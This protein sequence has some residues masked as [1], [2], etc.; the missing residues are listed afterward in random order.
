MSP[1]RWT[2][3]VICLL[4]LGAC[5][6]AP[7]PT[8]IALLP[9]ASPSP[10]T[11]TAG[12]MATSSP[13]P[14]PS[15]P[16][17]LP[18]TS[19]PSPLPATS[20]PVSIPPS[21]A[22]LSPTATQT[23]PPLPSPVTVAPP[24]G[25]GLLAW[26]VAEDGA[27]F[28]L[29]SDHKV[30][31]LEPHDLFPL[32]FS[33]ALFGAGAEAP[34][35]VAASD[36]QVFVSSDA[37]SRTLVLERE[38]L[39]LVGELEGFGPL[40]VG[41][42]GRLFMIPQYLE[43]LWPYG[44]FEIWVYD[45]TDL[46]AAPVKVRRTGMTFE[47]LVIDADSRRLYLL[48]SSVAASPP[49][50]GQ[51][52]A[53][54]DLDTLDEIAQFPWERGIL[55][56]PAI[57]PHTAEVLA[58][59]IG[60]NWSRRLLAF[61]QSGEEVRSLRSVDGQPAIDPAGRW[62]YLL[63][64]QGLWLL[65][66]KDLAVQG[67][68]P[69]SGPPPEDLALSPDGQILYL[70][71]NGWLEALPTAELQS[72]GLAPFGPLPAAWFSAGETLDQM[73][74]RVYRSP[75]MDSDGV[76]FVQMVSGAI[77]VLETYRTT[78]GGETWALLP[79][80]L[81]PDLVGVPYLSLSPN[82][83]QDRTL[84]V[85]R[86]KHVMRSTDG[87]LSWA[88]WQPRIAFSSDRDGNREIYTADLEGQDVRRV[89]KSPASEE[90]PAW[91]PAWTTLAFQSDRSGNWDIYTVQADCGGDRD[92]A[93]ALKQLTDS[94]GHD[95][96]PAW[97]PDGRSIAFVST[98]DGNP[99]IYVMDTDGGNQRRLTF[100]GGGDWRPAWR[101]NSR[102]LLFVSDRGGNNDI[103]QLEVPGP[104][105]G[106]TDAEPAVTPVVVGPAD[107]RDPAVRTEYVPRLVYLSDRDGIMRTYGYDYVSS[108]RPATDTDQ[109]EA[110]PATLTGEPYLILVT[111]EREGSTDIFRTSFY[112]DYEPLIASAGFDGQPA[113]EAVGWRPEFEPSLAWLE[114]W[115]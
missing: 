13:V 112:S 38:G 57:H 103:Y 3:L 109:P 105:D 60:L 63:R 61:D 100:D 54:W 5:G 77:N 74:A 107:D 21:P 1:K 19:H 36:S 18:P 17:A 28:V 108:P 70:L 95:M 49:H 85:V 58:S 9:S 86:D 52:Y 115:E 62:I 87:G 15:T 111:L 22:T 73:Q 25:E 101:T 46:D 80:L 89:T 71:G 69:F 114:A 42:D 44:N 67:L 47:D 27:V 78:D 93:C 23:P 68:L 50:E 10:A 65:R 32:A 55:S 31:E 82:F 45:L 8:P 88:P 99:E 30:F 24:S 110:H 94:P 11:S 16:S 59:R 102:Q 14:A 84:A 75:Q 33:A 66:N 51:S 41:P 40:S 104:G 43:K 81:R 106:S 12:V 56:R 2:A 90:N 7:A 53:V 26:T 6:P 37:I 64:R 76:A 29:D 39:G 4:C 20:T 48:Q 96:L 98:R 92:D 91:S 34:A 113:A 35:H 83:S 97:S 79:S 72:R